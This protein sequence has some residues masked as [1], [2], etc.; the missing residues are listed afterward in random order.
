VPD[1]I[2]LTPAL[3]TLFYPLREGAVRNVATHADAEHMTIRIEQDDDLARLI[4][5]DD[6]RGFE[7]HGRDGHLGLRLLADLAGEAGGQARADEGAE[8]GLVR[9]CIE[10]P[11]G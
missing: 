4:V 1:G 6:G 3:E 10:V 9:V 5:E 7:Q 2:Q 8:E 11:R